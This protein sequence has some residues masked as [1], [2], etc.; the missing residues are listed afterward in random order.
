[1]IFN[2]LLLLVPV[3]LVLT[4][5]VHAA[6]VWV[7]VSAVLAIVP[8]AEWIRRATEQL[9]KLSGPAIGGLFKRHLR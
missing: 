8:L 4:Y 2:W 3:P 9:A 1:M 6:P 7:F 5:V